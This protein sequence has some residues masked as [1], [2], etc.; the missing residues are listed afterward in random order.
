MSTGQGAYL[1]TRSAVLPISPAWAGVNPRVGITI[2]SAFSSSAAFVICSNALPHRIAVSNQAGVY[3]S[4]TQGTKSLSR[5][6]HESFVESL[7]THGSVAEI[8]NVEYRLDDV[9]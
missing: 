7:A 9:D 2:R 6:P 8:M 5:L 3:V 1:T 4:A